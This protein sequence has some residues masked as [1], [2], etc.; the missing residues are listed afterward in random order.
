MDFFTFSSYYSSLIEPKVLLIKLENEKRSRK[1]ARVELQ[2]PWKRAL[3]SDY[4]RDVTPCDVTTKS[5]PGVSRS[6]S[7]DL[8]EYCLLLLDRYSISATLACS[9]DRH[10]SLSLGYGSR[11]GSRSAEDETLDVSSLSSC[12]AAEMLRSLDVSL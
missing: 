6:S 8:V 2:S 4:K 7:V 5:V 1:P 11:E 3:L 10:R 12:S 9:Q